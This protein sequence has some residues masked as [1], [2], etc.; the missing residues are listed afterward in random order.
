MLLNIEIVDVHKRIN[1]IKRSLKVIEYKIEMF[2]PR[3][4]T[5]QYYERQNVKLTRQ[6]NNIRKAH[7]EKLNKLIE[8]QKRK[9]FVGP[10]KNWFVNLSKKN[11]P[12][13]I[14]EILALGPNFATPVYKE[15]LPLIEICT[16]IEQGALLLKDTDRNTFRNMAIAKTLYLKNNMADKP[17]SVKFDYRDVSKVKKFITDTN[18]LILR[19]DKGNTTVA[20][21]KENYIE[22]IKGILSDNNTYM[23]VKYEYTAT[24]EKENNKLIG[25]WAKRNFI[26]KKIASTL[27]SHFSATPRAYALP[28]IH[29]PSLSWRLIVDST[30]GPT[31]KLARFLSDIL[32]RVIGKTNYHVKD[33]WSLKDKIKDWRCPQDHTMISLDVISLFTNIPIDM[34]VKTVEKKDGHLYKNRLPYLLTNS[35][36]D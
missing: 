12:T 8:I 15:S 4:L 25:N 17:R 22:E 33:S 5:R 13:E 27:T 6:F 20:I 26:N 3:W 23:K 24:L 21:E 28:K 29:K 35:S 31:Y 7:I 34:V 16:A 32:Q 14:G 10:L 2:L 30:N 19:A 18:L 36:K 1:S 9:N 11:I